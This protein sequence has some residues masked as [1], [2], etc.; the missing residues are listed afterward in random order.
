MH[1]GPLS[2]WV[3]LVL[4]DGVLVATFASTGLKRAPLL[5]CHTCIQEVEKRGQLAREAYLRSNAIF[6]AHVKVGSSSL[7]A[8]GRVGALGVAL[9]SSPVMRG[10]DSPAMWYAAYCRLDQQQ[11]QV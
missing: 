9:S 2:H 6:L 1:S 3:A 5:F 11:C 8:T 10:C 4:A 7:P